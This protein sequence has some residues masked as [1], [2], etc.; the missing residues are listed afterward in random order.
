MNTTLY[1]GRKVYRSVWNHRQIKGLQYIYY[2]TTL[3]IGKSIRKNIVYC[4]EIFF[5]KVIVVRSV[6]CESAVNTRETGTTTRI[7]VL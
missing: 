3:Y 2:D 6:C 5:G 7:L 4:F 1:Y